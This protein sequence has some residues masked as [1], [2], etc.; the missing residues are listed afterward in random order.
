MKLVFT[1]FLLLM[2]L[3]SFA[4]EKEKASAIIRPDIFPVYENVGFDVIISPN[5]QLKKGDYVEC[6][7]ANSF[8]AEKVSPS[9]TKQW[10]FDNQKAKNYISFRT[11]EKNGA[12][13][14]ATLKKR[15]FAGG[16]ST[17]TRHGICLNIV[18][19]SGE[20]DKNGKIII[21]FKN[22]TSPWRSIENPGVG[23]H[24]GLVY[25]A[26]NGQ[27]I[28]N[29]PQF[30]VISAEEKQFKL[31]IPSS[32]KPDQKFPVRMVSLDQYNNLSYTTHRNVSV[33]CEGG[34]LA[35]G[36]N[37]CGRGE[38]WI[39]LPQKG[40]FRLEAEGTLSNPV[41]VTDAPDGP[42]WGDLHFHTSSSVDAVG[43][44][45]YKYARDI[46]C[47]DFA[48]TAEHGAGG[49]EKYW[50]Q[51][52]KDNKE[53]NKPGEFVTLVALE[54]ALRGK[55]F[56]G[57][58]HGPHYNMYIPID[59]APRLDGTEKGTTDPINSDGKTDASWNKIINYSKKYDIIG[60]THHTGWGF[61]MRIKF[62]NELKL[63]EIYSMHGQ[64][65]YF[66]NKTAL[67]LEN[68]RHRKDA[69]K[70]GY[71]YARDAW[72]LGKKWFTVGS[73]DNH[74]T[75]PGVYY[76]GICALFADSLSRQGIFNS[77]KR[78][79]TYATTGERIILEF[80][81]NGKPMGSE[82]KIT[83][84][85]QLNFN[86]S[87]NGTDQ[88]QKIEVFGCPYIEGNDNVEI[89]EPMFSMNDPKVNKATS[90]W[91]TVF[92]EDMI[93]EMDFGTNF[94]IPIPKTNMVYYMKVTQKNSIELP[95]KL[96]GSDFYQ[97]RPVVAWS[98]PIW[99]SL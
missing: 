68:Q 6:Q 28:D 33:K 23:A 89:G 72:A 56:L 82:V 81:I 17:E 11:G 70:E 35:T 61:D 53:F 83:S 48:S 57:K 9:F 80:N 92:E 36:I 75:Q 50:N 4:I 14:S 41:K 34:T 52:L 64:S 21:S 94:T 13:F 63:L 54:T 1:P 67:S 29:F 46:S 25:I 20:V 8:N 3:S 19:D 39:S 96:E 69:G 18:L 95:C 90:S 44:E 99:I 59:E 22:T 10:Q 88:L 47:L 43:N 84:G 85:N 97:I 77:L 73:S 32:V 2:T 51:T 79:T 93:Q 86:L 12:K 78:G 37:F 15:E 7:L 40:V 60:Q 27:P 66:D 58:S 55:I 74:F 26:V 16:Y 38:I 65:E 30:K 91:I 24:E 45:P 71:F 5:K 42:F 98:S 87:V 31:I 76:N 49:L 62:P